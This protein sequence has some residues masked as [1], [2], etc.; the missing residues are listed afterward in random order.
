[1]II[2]GGEK[3]GSHQESNPG[4]LTCAASVLPLSYDNQTTIS[5]HNPLYH[6]YYIRVGGTECLSHS[7]SIFSHSIFAS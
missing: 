3:D 4:H 2:E 7:Y 1:M 5:P 6:K